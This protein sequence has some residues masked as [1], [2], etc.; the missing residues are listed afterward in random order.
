[1]T[2]PERN[3][4][5]ETHKIPMPEAAVANEASLLLAVGTFIASL[6]VRSKHKR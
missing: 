5:R 3:G 2:A 6:F 1:M 4:D